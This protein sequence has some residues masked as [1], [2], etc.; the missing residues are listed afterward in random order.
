MITV[1]RYLVPAVIMFGL[2]FGIKFSFFPLSIS[3]LLLIYML[4][5]AG[6]S[7]SAKKDKIIPVS[8]IYTSLVFLI[9]LFYAGFIT[10]FSGTNDFGFASKMIYIITDPILGGVVISLFFIKKLKF[11]ISEILYCTL[12]ATFLQSVLSILSYFFFGLNAFFSELLPNV[13]N[14]TLDN[15]SRVRGFSNLGGS[16]LSVMVSLGVLAG[17]H[18]LS[19]EKFRG[20][21]FGISLKLIVCLASTIVIGRTGLMLSLLFI[22]IYLIKWLS[23][24]KLI[25]NFGMVVLTIIILAGGSLLIFPSIMDFVSND[26]ISWAFELFMKSDSGSVST[27][28]TDDLL[29]MLF[30]PHNAIDLIFGVG[31]YEHAIFG[32]ARSDSG[33]VK[34][35]L[36]VGLLGFTLFYL[37]Y[38]VLFIKIIKNKIIYITKTATFFIVLVSMMLLVEIKEPYLQTLGIT[39]FLFFIFFYLTNPLCEKVNE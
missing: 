20:K 9:V 19:D 14:L 32:Y 37:T 12:L 18:L 4:L 30:L 29:S 3:K 34:T 28:S 33:Y 39:N 38:I 17:L 1:R 36:S 13:G 8:A 6:L 25:R 21:T 7:F 31:F 15:T 10:I 11:S 24:G 35:I 2:L 26:T 5:W 27:A 16:W 22:L 23:Q